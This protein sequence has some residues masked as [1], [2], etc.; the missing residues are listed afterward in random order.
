MPTDPE[1]L[2]AIAD[3]SGGRAFQA[4][5]DQ[6]LSEIYRALGSRLGTRDEERKVTSAFAVAGALLLLGAGAREHDAP[7]EAGCRSAP[8]HRSGRFIVLLS[9]GVSV[10]TSALRSGAASSGS[11]WE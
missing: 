10:L 3:A 6:Q 2:Q 5:D 1:T 11:R 9:H 7:A 8:P 4:Q